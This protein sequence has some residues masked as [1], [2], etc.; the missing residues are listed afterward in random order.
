M[1]DFM[2]LPQFKKQLGH[3]WGNWGGFCKKWL[4]FA[5]CH[6]SNQLG[7]WGTRKIGGFLRISS[8]ATVAPVIPLRGNWGNDWGNAEIPTGGLA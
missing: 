5:V 2:T 6:S 4:I 3:N 1:G 8:P 7:H